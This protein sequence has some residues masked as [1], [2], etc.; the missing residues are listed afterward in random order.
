MP[1]MIE[2]LNFCTS[3]Q[4]ML[5]LL[6]FL[7]LRNC[8]HFTIII[9]IIVVIIIDNIFLIFIGQTTLNFQI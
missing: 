7:S 2:F 3:K 6:Y 5:L 8:Y 4:H 9:I 1:S